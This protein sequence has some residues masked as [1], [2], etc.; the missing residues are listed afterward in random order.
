MDQL[1]SLRERLLSDARALIR[2]YE[3][4]IANLESRFGIASPPPLYEGVVTLVVCGIARIHTLVAIEEA[5]LGIDG[6][7]QAF[8]RHYDRGEA[9]F[10]VTL[11]QP[12][13]LT[14][15]LAQVLPVSFEVRSTTANEIVL[16]LEDTTG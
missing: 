3:D 1:Q 13:P 5:L 7:I 16:A 8:V 6:V 2:S 9:W 10:E 12:V 14:T 15:Q 11:E 4:E